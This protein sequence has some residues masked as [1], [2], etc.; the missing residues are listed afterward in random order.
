MDVIRF[1]HVGEDE[2]L[3]MRVCDGEWRLIDNDRQ[4]VTRWLAGFVDGT[5]QILESLLFSKDVKSL[6]EVRSALTEFMRDE[7]IQILQEI[8]QKSVDYKL[9]CTD[10]LIRVFA[11][12][13]DVQSCLS[14]RYEALVMREQKTTTDPRLQ[15]SCAEWLI[16]AENLLDHNFYSIANNGCC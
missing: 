9:L 2:G 14:L 16:F 3:E 10:F 1:G 13:G 11:L 12:I 8:S 5:L 6:V 4:G 15:V 7:S